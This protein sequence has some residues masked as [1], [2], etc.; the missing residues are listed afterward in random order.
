MSDQPLTLHI[1]THTVP[2]PP[3]FGG[4]IDVFYK[5][6]AFY[7]EGVKIKLHCFTYNRTPAKELEDYCEEVHYYSRH[8]GLSCFF[9][10]S[11]YI[12]V[13]RKNTTLLNNLLKD[14]NPVFFDGLHTTSFLSHPS[15]RNRVKIVRTH[16]IEHDYYRY[17]ARSSNNILKKFYYYTEAVKLKR[18]EPVL[19]NA[20]L[21]A[22]IS[23]ND[24]DHFRLFADCILIP[25]FHKYKQVKSKEGIGDYALYH[26][27]LSTDENIHAIKYL[28]KNVFRKTDYPLIIAGK[29]P[30]PGLRKLIRSMS[31]LTLVENPDQKK[32]EELIRNAQ[33]IMLITFQPT[34]LKL[35]LLSSLYLGRHII[36]NNEMINQTG[37]EDLCLIC[38][39]A[40]EIQEAVSS[41]SEKEF[42]D[43]MIKNRIKKVS[44]LFDNNIH[45]KTLKDAIINL[46]PP[47]K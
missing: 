17:L 40:N 19:R 4:A 38:N 45:I 2:Y 16:N 44:S 33:M 20:A 7:E 15:L 24:A 23:A 47:Q 30:G 31:N 1:I 21:L 14:N 6:K 12:V 42:T 9:R 43:E 22:A 32:N 28:I 29:N 41:L 27:D 39:T 10:K 26:A 37:V 25:A 3:D 35:K 8:S 5:I 36:A 46:N 13:T 18:Y 34:G 11:P